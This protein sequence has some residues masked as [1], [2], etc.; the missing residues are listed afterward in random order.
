MELGKLDAPV[1][2]IYWI[3]HAWA[4]DLGLPKGGENAGEAAEL[5]GK[6]QVTLK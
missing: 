6:D 2:H 1:D 5:E 3:A 4:K